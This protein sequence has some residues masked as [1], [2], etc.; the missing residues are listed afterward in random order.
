MTKNLCHLS[1]PDASR[2]LRC[3]PPLLPTEVE[4]T[5][6]AHLPA[7]AL[8]APASKQSVHGISTRKVYPSRLL[9]AGIVRSYRT[10]SPLPAKARSAKAGLPNQRTCRRRVYPTNDQPTAVAS[11]GKP[12]KTLAT[13]GSYFLR[14][15]LCLADFS[16]RLRRL[17][18]AVLCVVRTFLPER[19]QSGLRFFIFLW[20]N[21]LLLMPEAKS[22]SQI[23]VLA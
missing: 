19:R 16:A 15:F 18:G 21:P 10:F 17:G 2:D 14:H 12:T 3:L 13:T 22:P 4:T 5:R 8:R 23:S 6:A 9:P 1:G 11:A 20:P 7:I